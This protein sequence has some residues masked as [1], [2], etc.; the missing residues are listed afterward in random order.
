MSRYLILVLCVACIS[1]GH[2]LFKSIADTSKTLNSFWELAFEPIFIAAVALY[3]CTTIGWIWCLR[4]IPLTRAYLFMS[5]AYVFIPLM[6][7]YQFGEPVT[8][9]YVI[10]VALIVTGIM[11]AIQ[12]KV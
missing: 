5:L 4:E 12:Q 11:L 1:F 3:G 9:Q 6:A 10:S 2:I 8:W 7:W